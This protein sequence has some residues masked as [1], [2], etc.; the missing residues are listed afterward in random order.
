MDPMSLFD[1]ERRTGIA[2]DDV[3]DFASRMDMVR[4]ESS[5]IYTERQRLT[6]GG[7]CVYRSPMQWRR[8]RMARST[9]RS[10]RYGRRWSNTLSALS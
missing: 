7:Y 8:S 4:G 10:A 1:M 3:E 6:A 2:S 9:R 5:M